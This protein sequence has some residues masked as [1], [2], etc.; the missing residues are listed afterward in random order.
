[1]YQKLEDNQDAN[2]TGFESPEEAMQLKYDL[3]YNHP[4]AD[5][6]EKI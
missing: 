1:M 2:G 6:K 3:I 4:A 5:Q